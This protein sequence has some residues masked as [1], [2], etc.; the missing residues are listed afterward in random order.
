MGCRGVHILILESVVVV[1]EEEE[2]EED[3][4]EEEEEVKEE[5]LCVESII[6]QHVTSYFCF[7]KQF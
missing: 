1:C 6:T 3:K 7:S 2:K 4:Q 5:E